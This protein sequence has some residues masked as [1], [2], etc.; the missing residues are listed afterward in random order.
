M[1]TQRGN[2]YNVDHTYTQDEFNALLRELAAREDLARRDLSALTPTAGT[3]PG[4]E[5]VGQEGVFRDAG[6]TQYRA[7]YV[8]AQGRPVDQYIDGPEGRMVNP[9]AQLGYY[10][11][12]LDQGGPGQ[13]YN[14]FRLDPSMGVRD[15]QD[16]LLAAQYN[17]DGTLREITPVERTSTSTWQAIRPV[18]A[19]AG[20]A[21]GGGWLANALQGAGAAGAQA[22]GA[23]AIGGSLAPADLIAGVGANGLAGPTLTS[24]AGG[25][26]GAAASAPAIGGSLAPADLIAGTG[27]NGLA[28]P[29][30]T[31][32]AGGTLPAAVG[33]GGILGQGGTPSLLNRI[34]QIGDVAGDLAPIAGLAGLGAG[35]ATIQPP[36]QPQ[37][38]T[39]PGAEAPPEARGYQAARDPI[40][41]VLNRNRRQG[42]NRTMLTGYSGVPMESVRTGGNTLLGL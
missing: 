28:G 32:G 5:A 14:T 11:T 12:I 8:D 21:A 1:A 25:L 23:Q 19:M 4:G 33:A 20:L 17:P 26:L 39:V 34:R 15:N 41:D 9:A 36:V 29:T 2:F 16:W 22:A 10:E 24:G 7:V 3:T 13:G 18:A 42:G 40:I 30:L 27:A 37:A 6:G 38:P 35:A 31:S